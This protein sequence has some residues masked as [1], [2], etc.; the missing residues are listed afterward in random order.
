M[1]PTNVQGRKCEHSQQYPTT[2]NSSNMAPQHR[3]HL[4]LHAREHVPM[5]T[6]TIIIA[7][8]LTL[9]AIFLVLGLLYIYKAYMKRVKRRRNHARSHRHGPNN[10][11]N[12]TTAQPRID[13]PRIELAKVTPINHATRTS[14]PQNLT[15]TTY[16]DTW[17]DVILRSNHM[18]TLLHPRNG[19]TKAN[20]NCKPNQTW[21]NSRTRN[22]RRSTGPYKPEYLKE[23][24][25]V[26][27]Q[28][29]PTVGSTPPQRSVPGHCLHWTCLEFITE[30]TVDL[31]G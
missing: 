25:A 14:R 12:Q 22:R 27:S 5:K 26:R 6:S 4:R 9:G 17:P 10:C 28:W 15:G 21:R 19:N 23:R 29:V 18:P 24:K 3:P 30:L 8:A 7:T 1:L 20:G 2:T 16:H 13:I 31:D 11:R